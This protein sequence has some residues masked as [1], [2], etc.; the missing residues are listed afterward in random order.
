LSWPLRVDEAQVRWVNGN[1]FGLQ[2]TLM[3]PEERVKLRQVIANLNADK[4]R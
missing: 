4:R 1:T 3:H 2:F